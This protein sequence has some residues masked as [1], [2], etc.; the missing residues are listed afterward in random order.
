M[1][2]KID[3]FS[4]SCHKYIYDLIDKIERNKNP[5]RKPNTAELEMLQARFD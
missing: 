4:P 1:Y 2:T 5:L 3:P